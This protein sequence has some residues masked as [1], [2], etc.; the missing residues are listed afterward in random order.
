MTGMVAAWMGERAENTIETSCARV[1]LIGGS[2][3]KV[4]NP[5]AAAGCGCGSSFAV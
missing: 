4:E 1:F 5:L 3:F 2:A